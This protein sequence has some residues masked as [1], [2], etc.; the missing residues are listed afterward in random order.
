MAA[1]SSAP[2]EVSAT[3]PPQAPPSETEILDRLEREEEDEIRAAE[4]ARIAEEAR[5]AMPPA[6][7]PDAEAIKVAQSYQTPHMQ[8]GAG[9][10]TTGFVFPQ[11]P[12]LR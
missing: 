9:A 7:L 11:P 4:E 3:F 1:Q 5:V 6:R 10:V 12:N 2:A 8:S